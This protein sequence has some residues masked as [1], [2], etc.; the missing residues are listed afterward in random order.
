MSIV[1]ASSADTAIFGP[2][3]VLGILAI[4]VLVIG[5]WIWVLIDCIKNEP[6]EG[7]DRIVWVVVI[8][9]LGVLGALI[10]LFARRPARKSQFGK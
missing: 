10:Y 6:E 3:L 1:A 8:A 5:L 2:I 4:V 7:N 9:L